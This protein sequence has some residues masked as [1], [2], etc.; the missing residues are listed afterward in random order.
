MPKQSKKRKPGSPKLAEH[1]V[2]GKIVPVRF[3]GVE[4]ERVVESTREA[5]KVDSQW[6]RSILSAAMGA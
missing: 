3:I 2:T 1:E 6:V 5:E 4:Y